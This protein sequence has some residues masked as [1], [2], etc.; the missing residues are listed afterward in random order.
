MPRHSP[1]PCSLHPTVL[2]RLLVVS[3]L[4]LRLLAGGFVLLQDAGCHDLR[5]E[6]RCGT[7]EDAGV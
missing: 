4:I 3:I 6:P 2:A 1:S 5:P 7:G